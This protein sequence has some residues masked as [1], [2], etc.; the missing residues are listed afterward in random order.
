MTGAAL[1]RQAGRVVRSVRHRT[2]AAGARLDRALRIPREDAERGAATVEF[3]LLLPAFLMVFISS[4]DASI[5]LVRQ[6]MLER[7]VDIVMRE[8]RL[9]ISSTQTQRQLTRKI[10]DRAQILPDC[11]ENMLI[12]MTE[13]TAPLYE[14]PAIDAPC[15]NQLTSIVPTS[16]FVS[17][18]RSG[19]MIILRACYSVQP[20]LPLAILSIN[21]T[22]ASNLINNDDGTVR[23]VT[24]TAFVVE[25]N[26]ATGTGS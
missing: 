20:V 10:C 17:A 5:L 14:T 13:V 24:S 8:V 11:R 6:V 23:M 3:V 26:Q 18:N 21:R 7:A 9:D 22:L 12:E 16:N 19:R 25:S 15:V 1:L 2:G 4:F